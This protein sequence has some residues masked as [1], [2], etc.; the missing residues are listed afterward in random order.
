MKTFAAG[1]LVAASEAVT[2]ESVYEHDHYNQVPFTVTHYETVVGTHLEPVVDEITYDI[3]GQEVYFHEHSNG[4]GFGDEDSDSTVQTIISFSS[5]DTHDH[6]DEYSESGYGLLN[7]DYYSTQSGEAGGFFRDHNGNLGRYVDYSDDD[8]IGF[9]R[10]PGGY[11]DVYTESDD[12]YETDDGYYDDYGLG[13]NEL[14]P[15]GYGGYYGR[16]HF[17]PYGG[18]GSFEGKPEWRGYAGLGNG[19]YPNGLNDLGYGGYLGGIDGRGYGYG[20]FDTHTY[21]EHGYGDHGHETSD[22]S[23]DSDGSSY[24]HSHSS[25][26]V[27]TYDDTHD[28]HFHIEEYVTAVTKPILDF[29]VVEHAIDVP[30]VRP[31][32]REEAYTHG[33]HDTF[34]YDFGRQE[35]YGYEYD[36]YAG[37][38]NGRLGNGL[39]IPAYDIHGNPQLFASASKF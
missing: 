23:Y 4:T 24:S 17:G 2:L 30:Y 36:S 34:R 38:S 8:R 35:G 29:E 19:G 37:L 6:S 10:G 1:L 11:I 32:F 14:G 22:E 18:L 9:T 31:A 28:T 15:G 27:H 5:V 13:Y 25:Y 3:K 26:S 16:G 39:N 20:A 21:A 7:S 33:D 12:P